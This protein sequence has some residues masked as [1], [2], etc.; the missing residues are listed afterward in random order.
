MVFQVAVHNQ[1]PKCPL[2]EAVHAS[3]RKITD[4]RPTFYGSRG[5]CEWFERHKNYFF[6]VFVHFQLELNAVFFLSISIDK[7]L[8]NWEV[9]RKQSVCCWLSLHRNDTY[10][11]ISEFSTCPAFFG[12]GSDY[13]PGV[14]YCADSDT[15][16]SLCGI[17]GKK[18]IGTKACFSPYIIVFTV[19]SYSTSVPL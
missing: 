18:K 4:C 6:Q 12:M 1:C 13:I 14:L 16:V 5:G 7:N 8:K 9:P 10:C 15:Q 11:W 3:T 19:N 17:C 2:P